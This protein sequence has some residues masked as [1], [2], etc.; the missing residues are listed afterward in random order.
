MKILSM[1]WSIYDNRL[2]EFCNNCTGG[3][4]AIK[5][6][7]EYIGRKQES[8]LFI[9]RCKMP[10]MK[11]G[12]INIVGTD[13]YPDVE[14]DCPD[15]NEKRLRTMTWAFESAVD[16]IVPDIVNFHG[17]GILMQRCIEI[18]RNKSI[19]YVYTDHLFIE[20]N[21]A[22]AGYNTNIELQKSIYAIP[23]I[24]VIAVSSGMKRKILRDFPKV[25]EE[26]IYVIKNGTDFDATWVEGDLKGKYGLKNRK[27]LLSVGTI[28]NRKNQSQIIK[29]FQL[30]PA[31]LQDEIKIIFCGNDAMDGE[32]Q[33]SIIE[34]ELQDNLIYAGALSSNEMKKCYS[35]ADG[36]IMPSYAEGLSIAA[37]EAIAYGLP[38]IMFLDSECAE[39]L[40]DEKVV[41][42]A[43]ERSDVCLARSI[44]EWY[45]KEWNRDYIIDYAKYFTMERVAD[46]YIEYY[47]RILNSVNL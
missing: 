9:G 32:L 13:C 38:V 5:N 41:C 20:N 6:I 44:E 7:C 11:L 42:F 46:E 37:L 40:G 1:A 22:F 45:G 28:S 23:D 2:S 16:R 34:A 27:V 10:E 24:R 39:D 8:Y 29:A 30:L 15:V 21:P 4:L 33:E 25:S 18:C 26:S 31:S 3:G 17:A 35:I 19:P 43:K 36:L 14:D 12:N 47:N